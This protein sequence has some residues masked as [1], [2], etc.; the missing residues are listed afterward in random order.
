MNTSAESP[1]LPKP[2]LK[3]VLSGVFGIAAVLG[4]MIGLGILRT[5]GEIAT[6]VNDPWLFTALWL[7][8]G[9]FVLMSVGVAAE[10]VGMTPRSGG[11]YVLVRRAFGR[12]PGFV[13]GW[14]DWL[15]FTATIALKAAVVVE[16]ISLLVPFEDVYR[17]AVA[18]L[19]T[20]VFA[21]V[22][23]RGVLLS[24]RVQEVAAACMAMIV[25]G[26]TLAL[27]LGNGAPEMALQEPLDSSL[28]GWGLVAAA[29][30][31][32]YDGWLYACYFGGEIK[33]GGGEV[34]R[35]CVRGVVAVFIL[36]IGLMAALA[37]SVPLSN[38]VGED[39]ALATALELAVSPAAATTV[40]VAAILIL[41]A[42]QNVSYLAGSRVLYALSA[43]HLGID[44]AAR[45]GKRG[46]PVIAVLITWFVSV[47]LILVGGFEFLLTLN[48][49]LF[50]VLYVVLIAGVALLRRKRP[51]ADRPFR[52]WG[53]PLTTVVCLVGWMA[54]S[55]FQAYTAPETAGYAL[56]MI[57]V[58]LPVYLWLKRVRHL[59][60]RD[61]IE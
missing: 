26:F 8:G 12:Y 6:I 61:S 14:V 17:P 41:L 9:I 39:L 51:D 49:F 36:Y 27:L 45:V 54:M 32:T 20:S 13:I 11:V 59:D 55:L 21:L 56:I 7:L 16:Y 38:L 53:H 46:N 43:D 33:G 24:A 5:P 30:I 10:L 52:A 58:S 48:V 50:I 34:A 18:I 19:V 3:R 23:L 47:G 44:S 57:A 15:S 31:F 1:S 37:F 29:I 25:I 35:S 42:H 4:T 28:A 22:Q 2:E 40:V 60:N